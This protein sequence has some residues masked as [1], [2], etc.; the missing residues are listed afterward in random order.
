M[1]QLKEWHYG[2]QSKMVTKEVP[3]LT[4]SH[5]HTISTTTHGTIPSEEKSKD[6]LSDSYTLSEQGKTHTEMGMKG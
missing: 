3:E 2:F 6:Q 1:K 5:G 4:S